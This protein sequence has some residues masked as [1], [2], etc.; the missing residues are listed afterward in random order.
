MGFL[1][2][3][4]VFLRQTFGLGARVFFVH[5]SFANARC[6]W[7]SGIYV[8]F[9]A[10]GPEF[11]LISLTCNPRGTCLTKTLSPSL[12]LKNMT[13]FEELRK[14]VLDKIWINVL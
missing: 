10:H 1:H 4:A 7:T 9:T 12:S 6:L 8:T 14:L 2:E 13:F 3:R 5:L 11:A